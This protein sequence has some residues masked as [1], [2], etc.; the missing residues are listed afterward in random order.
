M[1]KIIS[2]SLNNKD[3]LKARAVKLAK[4]TVSE[5][6][7]SKE[8]DVVEFK[9]ARETYGIELKFIRT[10]YPLKNLTYIPGAP[11]FIKGVIN[12][13]GEI[14]SVVDLKKFFDLPDQ[15]LTNLSQVI[16]LSSDTME[17]GILADEIL[18]VMQIP[19]ASIQP[20]LPTL[21]GI[22]LAYL[23]GV[24]GDSEVILDGDKLLADEKMLIYIETGGVKD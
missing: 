23:K 8:L 4:E 3:I 12:L 10:I 21:T 6:E 9:I 13:R 14:I 2:S 24:T 11:D 18:D 16:I 5:K 1:E 7:K 15:E 22:R 17:F 19:E 20:S